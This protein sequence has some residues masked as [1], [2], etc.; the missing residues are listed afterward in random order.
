MDASVIHDPAKFYDFIV[1]LSAKSTEQ[2]KF[3]AAYEELMRLVVTGFH[4]NIQLAAMEGRY[5]AYLCIYEE[6]SQHQNI[7]IHDY[8]TCADTI[9]AKC[10]K[11]SVEPLTERIS[12]TIQPFRIEV[13]ALDACPDFAQI[14]IDFADLLQEWKFHALIVCWDAVKN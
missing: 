6:H 3:R 11:Y 5:T 13:R 7:P 4:T 2:E 14:C 10:E 1:Q 8:F 12:K 9:R